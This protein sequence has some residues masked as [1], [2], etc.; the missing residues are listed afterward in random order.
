MKAGDKVLV[1][2]VWAHGESAW[3]SGY[4]FVEKKVIR[5]ELVCVVEHTRGT[6]QGCKMNMAAK[7]VKL[8]DSI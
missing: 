8:D 4:I 2:T 3:V 5:N 7:N 6:F 1:K